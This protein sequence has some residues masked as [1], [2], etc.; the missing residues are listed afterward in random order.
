MFDLLGGDPVQHVLDASRDQIATDP[1]RVPGA[2]SD[3]LDGKA[4][5]PERLRPPGR[6]RTGTQRPGYAPGAARWVPGCRRP[7]GQMRAG[8]GTTGP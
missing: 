7:V 2:R 5:E 4:L 6:A 8:H 3:Q 1:A